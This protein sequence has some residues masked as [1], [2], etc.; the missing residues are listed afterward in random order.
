MGIVVRDVLFLTRQFAIQHSPFP[1]CIQISI[2]N[3]ITIIINSII[4][5]FIN[6]RNT[7]NICIIVV[8]NSICSITGTFKVSISIITG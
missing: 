1:I 7:M 4:S 8:I 3:P 2:W 5:S 6:H